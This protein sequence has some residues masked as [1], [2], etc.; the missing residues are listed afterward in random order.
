MHERQQYSITTATRRAEET[1]KIM[2]DGLETSSVEKLRYGHLS[3]YY[4]KQ[5]DENDKYVG[6]YISITQWSK[7]VQ[8]KIFFSFLF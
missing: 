1:C 5:D 4:K 6:M 8:I 3:D 7:T 2:D